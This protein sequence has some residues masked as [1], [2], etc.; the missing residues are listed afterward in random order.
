MG[1]ASVVLGLVGTSSVEVVISEVVTDPAVEPLDK[2]V[3]GTFGT[4]VVLDSVEA[5]KVV[6]ELTTVEVW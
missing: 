6:E 2:V 5:I 3:E 4:T 1:A